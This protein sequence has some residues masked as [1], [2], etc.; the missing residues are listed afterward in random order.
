MFGENTV[1]DPAF[2]KE[3]SCECEP[4]TSP[5]QPPQQEHCQFELKE[6]G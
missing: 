3:D 4:W 2:S 6:M 5:N 1:S